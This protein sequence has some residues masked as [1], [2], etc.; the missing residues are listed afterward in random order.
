MYIVILQF[1]ENNNYFNEESGDCSGLDWCNL[2]GCHVERPTIAGCNYVTE[3][4]SRIVATRL[5]VPGRLSGTLYIYISYNLLQTSLMLLEGRSNL[6]DDKSRAIAVPLT[7]N[8]SQ[9]HWFSGTLHAATGDM[10]LCG[11]GWL[12]TEI[13]Y[14]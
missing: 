1:L 13:S 6:D 12:L 3:S 4:W 5:W 9:Q 11:F 10:S 14:M 7:E 2:C 8:S